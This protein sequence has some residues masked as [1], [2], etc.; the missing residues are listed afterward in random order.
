MTGAPVPDATISS[1]NVSSAPSL[2]E[3]HGV[4]IDDAGNIAVINEAGTS[5]AF[6]IAIFQL[7]QLQTGA[8]TPMT[9]ITG[10]SSTLNE[11]E[12]CAFG[13]VVK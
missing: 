12:G 1:T 7:A 10:K 4:C 6:G 11:P 2:D 8:P 13:P 5:G 3:P 9:L